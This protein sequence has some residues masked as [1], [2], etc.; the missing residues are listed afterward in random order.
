MPAS[1]SVGQLGTAARGSVAP[2]SLGWSTPSLG[3]CSPALGTQ[4]WDMTQSDQAPTALELCRSHSSLRCGP[5]NPAE[6]SLGW[7][8]DPQGQGRGGCCYSCCYCCCYYLCGPL[9]WSSRP[10]APPGGRCRG[11][12][13][14]RGPTACLG[15]LGRVLGARL[16]CSC[17]T[18]CGSSPAEQSPGSWRKRW[19]RKRSSWHWHAARRPQSAGADCL[20]QGGRIYTCG[21]KCTSSL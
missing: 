3:S 6:R 4:R 11:G 19:R 16:H 13:T 20:S 5:S 18:C 2:P 17:W 10:A 14:G 7:K 9:L 21:R 15:R 8:E 1:P 12:C